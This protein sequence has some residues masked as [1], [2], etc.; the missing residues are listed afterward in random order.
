MGGGGVT[1]NATGGMGPVNTNTG[2]SMQQTSSKQIPQM[3]NHHPHPSHQQLTNHLG[4][5]NHLNSTVLNHALN[6]Q[7]A[8]AAAAAAGLPMPMPT[9]QGNIYDHMH[10]SVNMNG[11][12]MPKPPPAPQE[13]LVYLGGQ[14]QFGMLAPQNQYMTAANRTS[15]AVSILFHFLFS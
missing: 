7:A 9:I 8:A 4:A 5:P 11:V 1:G 3:L 2:M 15:A 14:P 6:N 12:G 13:Q 10:P